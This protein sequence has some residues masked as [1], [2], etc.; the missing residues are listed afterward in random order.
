VHVPGDAPAFRVGSSVGLTRVVERLEAAGLSV[1]VNS[2]DLT[3][4]LPAEIAVAVHRI[5]QESLTNTLRHA[6]ATSAVVDLSLR[7][8][9]L[10]LTITDD[11]RRSAAVREPVAGRGLIGI[12]ERAAVFG[13]TADAGPRAG[14]GFQV[15]AVLPVRAFEG[16]G[17]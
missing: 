10:L 14:G 9:H 8:D 5:V 7:G 6:G 11:G 16:V 15:R 4:H 12:R 3:D 17:A 13:G 2:P 1:K